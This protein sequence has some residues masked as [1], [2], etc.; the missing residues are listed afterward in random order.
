MLRN[1]RRT[2]ALKIL[3]YGYL[4]LLVG[5]LLTEE[6]RRD[7]R[8]FLAAGVM[9][10]FFLAV[11][12][13]RDRPR[14]GAMQAE[15]RRLG[16][17]YAEKDAFGLLDEPFLLFRRTR[18]S[19]GEV[20]NVLFGTWHGFEVKV[21]DYEYMIS[22]NNWRRLSGAVIA[23]AGGWPT[24]AIRPETLVTAVGDQ[25]ALPGIEFESEMFNRAFD[26]R[27]HDRGFANA[28]ID[29]RMMEWLLDHS[30]R[31]GFEISGRWIL[32]YRDQVQPWQVD[33]V[34]AMLESFVERI[35]RAVRS[36]YPE[37][38]PPRPDAYR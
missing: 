36:L 14:A 38:L 19:Y 29:A 6:G 13:F 26:L 9:I 11:A 31:A 18:S 4:F 5:A 8:Q 23:I 10:G 3:A 22:E 33:S 34:L 12:W 24:I 17:Q 35:P 25:L 7:L 15:A 21:F 2:T 30:P 16:L 20:D 28:L 1:M 27:S 32:G 37:A